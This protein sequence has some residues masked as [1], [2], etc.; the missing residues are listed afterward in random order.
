MS[1]PTL[2]GERQPVTQLPNEPLVR[3]RPVGRWDALE[4]RSVW[5][6]REL[7]FFLTLR[8]IRLRYK[9]TV[10][11]VLWVILQPLMT[12][13]VFSL[14]FGKL[15]G[16]P[17]DGV[18][19]PIFAYAGLLPWVFFSL[20]VTTSSNSLVGNANLI[21]KVYFPRLIIP[22][23][24]VLAALVDLVVASV[25]LGGLMVIYWIPARLSLLWLPFLVLVTALLALAAGLALS[26]LNLRYR[27][28]R[29][30]LPFLLQMLM[31]STPIIYP[32]SLVPAPWR[33]I[34][35]FNPLAGLIGSFRAAIFGQP[36]DGKALGWAVVFT[37][38]LLIGAAIYFRGTERRFADHV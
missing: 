8:D 16:I 9:Q 25:V 19:Y 31:F 6:Y 7:L 14:F 17:S 12:M 2:L 33:P 37:V 11:G 38:L 28:V 30:V 36:I 32:A 4:I 3:I 20:A 24:A 21:S 35:Q 13:V 10:M 15:A 26:A 5:D 22:G 29:L 1:D 34:V 27:D 23:A 18:P